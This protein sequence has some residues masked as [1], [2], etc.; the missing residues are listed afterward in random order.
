MISFFSRMF[1]GTNLQDL[2]LDWIARRIME[3][4]KGIIA[5]W[6]N[7]QNQHWMVYDTAAET[8]VD[9]GVSAA[10]EGTGPQGEPGKSPIIGSN[11]DWYTWDIDTQA[12]TDTGTQ[13]AGP[14][15]PQGPAGPTGPQGPAGYTI[16]E[17]LLAN[18]YF[19]G[20]GSQLA[21]GRFP[22]NQRRQTSYAIQSPARSI[23]CWT[24]GASLTNIGITDA[25]ITTDKLIEQYVW[26]AT[27]FKGK[28]LTI[29]AIVDGVLYTD[30]A[31]I[32]ETLP[33]SFAWLTDP[34]VS[35]VHA[36]IAVTASA[37]IAAVSTYDSAKVISAVKLE[38][39]EVQSLAQVTASG[40]VLN[41]VPVFASELLKCQRYFQVFRT[42]ALRPTYGED[43][44]PTMATAQPTAGTMVYDN[45]TYYTL[46]S[47]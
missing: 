8:F 17:N 11:G 32:P 28:R 29:S 44:R 16:R 9:S 19:V 26:G 14:A 13:A 20:G 23:D 21:D 24:C 10:G 15:G 12:Y 7:A 1:P 41:E 3:L 45:T 47:N 38:I 43:C 25:G 37:V 18:P 5:P 27:G 31:V 39:G 46:T 42:E 6:I 40:P 4:S 33:A 35:G 22:I 2:N 36:A 30:S 34:P